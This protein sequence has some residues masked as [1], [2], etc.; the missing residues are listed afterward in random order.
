MKGVLPLAFFHWRQHDGTNE[1]TPLAILSGLSGAAKGIGK[2]C[3]EAFV[4]RGWRVAALDRDEAILATFT[5][6]KQ[7]TSL[8]ADVANP[9]SIAVELGR[10]DTPATALVNAAGLFPPT[11][12]ATLEVERYRH[13]FDVNVLGTLLLSQLA[14]RDMVDGGAIVNFASTNAFVPRADQII[15]AATKASAVSLTRSMAVDL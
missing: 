3:V 4:K 8:V 9:A 1:C 6:K 15:Y 10:F 7:V 11:S 5:S 13:I 2:A 14:S 12:L